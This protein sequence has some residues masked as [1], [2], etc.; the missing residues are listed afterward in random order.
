MMLLERYLATQPAM[1]RRRQQQEGGMV[2]R[3]WWREAEEEGG[4]EGG[5]GVIYRAEK[6]G[7][8]EYVCVLER[9]RN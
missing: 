8:S 9:I 1:T 2:Q 4:R 6:E 3:G 5:R 7:R